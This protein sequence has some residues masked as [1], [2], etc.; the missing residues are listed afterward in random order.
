M[1]YECTAATVPLIRKVLWKSAR[2][3]VAVTKFGGGAAQRKEI[4]KRP[5]SPA[6]N[7]GFMEI[8]L[9]AESKALLRCTAFGT[10]ETWLKK[11][12]RT[13]YDFEARKV[14]NI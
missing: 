1:L 7:D 3:T 2:L 11:A 12:N 4:S 13:I 14:L 5:A 8:H 6:D 9:F 10:V